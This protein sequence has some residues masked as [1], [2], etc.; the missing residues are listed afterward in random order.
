MNSERLGLP[1]VKGKLKK[2]VLPTKFI[3]HPGKKV[4]NCFIS[5]M[6]K[7]IVDINSSIT[8]EWICCTQEIQPNGKTPKYHSI[9][10]GLGQEVLIFGLI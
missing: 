5:C 7:Y 1:P 9:L 6:I 4:S 2:G 10:K 3:F 8:A